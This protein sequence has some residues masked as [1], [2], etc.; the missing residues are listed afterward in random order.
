MTCARPGSHLT[1]EDRQPRRREWRMF[2][3]TCP[4]C[5]KTI[6]TA[7][8]SS[9]TVTPCPGCG[10]RLRVVLESEA[11]A[12]VS[13]LSSGERPAEAPAASG[14]PRGTAGPLLVGVCGL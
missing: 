10:Q 9:G 1:E 4:K 3:Y 11:G 5:E 6:T 12:G 2:E 13:L 14:P 8:I 7:N